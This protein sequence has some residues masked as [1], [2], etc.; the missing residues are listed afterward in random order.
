[1]NNSSLRK[2]FGLDEK[3]ASS[4][5]R[6]LKEAVEKGLIRVVDPDTAPRYKRYIPYWA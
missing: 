5:S 6:L 3:N 4:I 2:R 1:M